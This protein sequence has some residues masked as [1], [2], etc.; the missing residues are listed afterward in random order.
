[1]NEP[2]REGV[3]MTHDET[4]QTDKFKE[5]ANETIL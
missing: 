4:Y 5:N 3:E 1:M 2:N